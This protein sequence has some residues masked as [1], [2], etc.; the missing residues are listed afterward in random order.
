M[1][2]KVFNIL[3]KDL[4]SELESIIKNHCIDVDTTLNS[5]KLKKSIAEINKFEILHNNPPIICCA[6]YLGSEKC[7]STLIKLNAN[8][9]CID[10]YHT[11]LTF[12]AVVGNSAKILDN[13]LNISKNSKYNLSFH[14]S[15]FCA[16]EYHSFNDQSNDFELAGW[17]Y[18]YNFFKSTDV[19]F[20][21]YSL[22]RCAIE[23]NRVEYL[24]FFIEVAKCQ[25]TNS[26]NLF[27]KCQESSFSP[28]CYAFEKKSYDCL[29]YILNVS[30]SKSQ[31]SQSYTS[32]QSI[33]CNQNKIIIDINQCD[34]NRNS[35]IHYAA[36][37][38][39]VDIVQKILNFDD[40]LVS[41]R[42]LQGK[43]PLELAANEKI[44]SLISERAE[45]NRKLEETMQKEQIRIQNE[46]KLAEEKK[47]HSQ[48]IP[49]QNCKKI[50]S[51]N[52][53]AKNASTACILI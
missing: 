40:V 36:Q 37:Y 6:A 46:K 1:D 25:L 9:E 15:I 48:I 17:L 19:D 7:F 8:V 30:I 11:P 16:L 49:G 35:V 44:A 20:R 53:M 18:S 28:L 5:E 4:E 32:L 42:N 27:M 22:V 47:S 29:N 23:F 45:K 39:D 10:F 34:E 24:R 12:F 26:A 3:K 21:G 52:M 13:L 41:T 50:V 43:T 14:N 33:M 31:Y 38:G 2:E 51:D